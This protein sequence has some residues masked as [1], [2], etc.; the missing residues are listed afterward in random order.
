V[1]L[2]LSRRLFVGLITSIGAAAYV[3]PRG[4]LGSKF[5]GERGKGGRGGRKGEREV[6]EK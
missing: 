1:G 2:E 6:E 4:N 3:N 5:K